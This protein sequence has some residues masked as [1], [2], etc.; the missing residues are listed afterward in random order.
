MTVTASATD[1]VATT[2]IA[3]VTYAPLSKDSL[4]EH[5]VFQGSPQFRVEVERE[6]QVW[7]VHDRV[8]GI[9][10]AGETPSEALG[11]FQRAAMEHLDVLERQ[12]ALSEDLQAQLLYLRERV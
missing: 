10:G 1:E 11:D 4:E 12:D 2:Y 5:Y 6:D 9:H 7:I 8:T 3:G